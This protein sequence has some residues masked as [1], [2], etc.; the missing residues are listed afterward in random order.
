MAQISRPFQIAFIVVV[1]LAG[2]W[3]FALQ[4]HSS[5]SSTSEPAA[6]APAA[7]AKA[8]AAVG[9]ASSEAGSAAAATP[10]YKGAAPGVQGLTRAI[11]KAHETVANSQ[12]SAAQVEAESAT[13]TPPSG[14]TT[15]YP[16]GK[17]S[18]AAAPASP[19]AAAAGA[20]A[21]KSAT[22]ATSSPAVKSAT[23]ATSSPAVKSVPVASKHQASTGHKTSKAVSAP[24]SS[25]APAKSTAAKPG[26]AAVSLANQ[27]S[28]EADIDAGKT[29]LIYFWQPSG[30]DDVAVRKQVQSV[31]RSHARTLALFLA[32][33]GEVATFGTITRGVQVY[34]TPTLMIVGKGGTTNVI[35]GLTD[36]YAIE[37]GIAET[38]HS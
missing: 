14:A 1:L 22:P 18:S 16:A 27:K 15:S 37:Q 2:V 35:T 34:G 28:A 20:P 36:A 21:V 7:P 25:K 24:L 30:F 5:N 3:L 29:V 33:P 31:A 13:A 9:S 4:G 10:I 11:A 32:A 38:A 6:P 17:S 8:T 26:S 19:T 12:K 23:P